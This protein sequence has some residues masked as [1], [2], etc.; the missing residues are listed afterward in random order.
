MI[1]SSI[2]NPLLFS[3]GGNAFS[4]AGISAFSANRPVVPLQACDTVGVIRRFER[5]G[6]SDKTMARLL[7]GTQHTAFIDDMRLARKVVSVGRDEMIARMRFSQIQQKRIS[8]LTLIDRAYSEKWGLRETLLSLLYVLGT[9]ESRSLLMCLR[10]GSV[11]LEFIS[12]LEMNCLASTMTQESE[13]CISYYRR[14]DH[15]RPKI[16]LRQLP[17]NAYESGTA[18][19]RLSI[20]RRLFGLIHEWDHW[21]QNTGRYEREECGGMSLTL[22][23]DLRF[24]REATIGEIMS[25]FEEHRAR[26]HLNDFEIRKRAC[27][28]GE[29][30][31]QFFQKSAEEAT[32]PTF[33]ERGA[34][35]LKQIKTFIR[36]AVA[37]WLER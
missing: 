20:L 23:A 14:M 18:F 17:A 9:Q 28:G 10:E 33:A 36:G 31:A 24:R 22:N 29:T 6:F 15:Q 2:P 7:N 37:R 35:L 30:L 25:M 12:D 16:Y 32:P 8:V 11:S 3:Q 34:E 13:S 21:R 26:V 4:L 5:Q 27:Q 19:F 1:L